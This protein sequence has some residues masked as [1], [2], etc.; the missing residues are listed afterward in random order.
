MNI[1]SLVEQQLPIDLYSVAN[2]TFT[3]TMTKIFL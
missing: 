3:S 1:T 2:T